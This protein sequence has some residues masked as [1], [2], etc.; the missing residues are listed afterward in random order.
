MMT[1]LR[2]KFQ[3]IKLL[4]GAQRNKRNIY[5]K[6]YALTSRGKQKILVLFKNCQQNIKLKFFSDAT[7][8]LA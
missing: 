1:I 3:N 5:S 4:D 6:A 8:I 2:G 7:Y